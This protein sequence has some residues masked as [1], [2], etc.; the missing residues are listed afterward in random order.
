VLNVRS[1]PSA[2]FEIVGGLPPG[3]RGIEITSACRSTWCPVQHLAASGWVNSAYL[4]AEELT[5]PVPNYSTPA[6]PAMALAAP[7]L[8]DS[9]DAPRT[10]LTA[11]ARSLLDRI[12]QQFGPVKVVSTCRTGGLIPG[13]TYPS[14][15]ASGNALDFLAGSRKSAIIEWLVANHRDG[16]TMTYAGMDHIHVDVGRHFVSIANGPRWLSWRDSAR[17]FPGAQRPA[18]GAN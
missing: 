12:E 8:R 6:G 14:R 16:G 13:T 10:C 4:A 15:H 2:D 1:G 18:S 17:D 11:A 3:S 5:S 7:G 9:P